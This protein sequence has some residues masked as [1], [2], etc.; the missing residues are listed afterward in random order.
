MAF[1]FPLDTLLRLRVSV[2]RKEELNLQRINMAL[3]QAR[4][5]LAQLRQER[6]AAW[7]EAQLRLRSSA[8][9]AEL[10]FELARDHAARQRAEQIEQRI[11]QLEFARQEQQ[12]IYRKARQEREILENLRSRKREQYD[13]ELSR[14]E[15]QSIDDMQ[16]MLRAARERE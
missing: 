4:H 9:A 13:Q 16:L 14:V 2:E 6:Q 1:R 5:D 8:P 3:L 12:Q 11:T 7:S 15:Q 10:H